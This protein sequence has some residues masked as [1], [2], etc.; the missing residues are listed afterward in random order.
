MK[1]EK[2]KRL[3]RLQRRKGERILRKRHGEDTGFC[4]TLSVAAAGYGFVRVELED[5]S[6]KEIFIP[7]QYL[8]NALDQDQV[9]V[10]LLPE[11][12]D[13]KGPAGRVVE[14]LQAARDTLVGEMLPGGVVRPLN[15]RIGGDLPLRG[16][17]KGARIGDWVQVKLLREDRD[18]AA[19]VSRIIGKAGSIQNDLNAIC[20]EFNIPPAYSAEEEDA[21]MALVPREMMREDFTRKFCVTIDPADAKDFDD[22]LSV[23]PGKDRSLLEVGVHIADVA[24]WIA[25]KSV[26]DDAAR[27]RGFSCYLPGRTLPMLPRNLTAKISLHQGEICPAHSVIF[28]VERASGKIVESRRCHTAIRVSAR[29]DYGEVQQF[30]DTGDAPEAWNKTFVS[31]MKMLAAVTAKVRRI[32]QEKEEFIDLAIPEMRVICDENADQVS[33]LAVKIQRESE[34][35]VE[36]WMLAANSAVGAELQRIGVAGLYR[37]HPE[38]EPEKL[39]EF[40]MDMV[41]N[42]G[43]STG[44]LSVRKQVLHFLASLP[45]TPARPVILNA[46]LRSMPRAS[47]SEKASLHYGLGKNCY[48]HFTSPIRRYADLTVHQQLWNFDCKM[49]TRSAGRLAAV[50]Q[51][52]S[53]LEERC[54][55]ASYA[56]NDRLK[57]RYLQEHLAD[58]TGANYYEGVIFRIAN[59]GFTVQ[60][61]ALGIT[62][63]VPKENLGIGFVRRGNRMVS[64]RMRKEYRCGDLVA[65]RLAD[66]DPVRALAE[67]KPVSR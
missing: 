2:K 7:P 42:F 15:R 3:N 53:E 47:Y 55:N 52:C 61:G 12:H 62:G 16:R 66:L 57:M 44:D 22:A 41:E 51:I 26:W 20:A 43:L 33:A 30:L 48:S 46:L 64:D 36:E 56:A 23:A 24:A 65:L 25:P 37:I 39:E 13:S 35:I 63:F 9:R 27:K 11:R 49:R 28:Q 60:I 31:K 19:G 10:A 45:D 50:A 6:V 34:A 58:G 40:S 67:F 59:S 21:A 5:G 1:K 4:G 8:Y 29:L 38:P 14:I 32:R 54:D 17:R 18:L